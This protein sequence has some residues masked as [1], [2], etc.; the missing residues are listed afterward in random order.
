MGA[1]EILYL[2]ACAV[3]VGVIVLAVESIM[4][5]ARRRVERDIDAGLHYGP[6]DD[7]WDRP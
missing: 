4:G 6:D 1:P 2:A 3:F 5:W 7:F